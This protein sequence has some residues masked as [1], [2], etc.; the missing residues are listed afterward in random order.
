MMAAKEA[1]A[2]FAGVNLD[3][4]AAAHIEFPGIS[5]RQREYYPPPGCFSH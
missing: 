4:E 5:R 3:T 1:E 2:E